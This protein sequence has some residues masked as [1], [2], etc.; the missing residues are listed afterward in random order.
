MARCRI[1]REWLSMLSTAS[2]A[3]LVV[4]P[5]L[6][7]YLQDASSAS[8]KLSVALFKDLGVKGGSGYTV[9]QPDLAFC[10]TCVTA[11]KTGKMKIAGNVKDSAFI[12]N[13]FCN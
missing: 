12:Y 7:K 3:S 5:K 11:I 9:S 1:A 4:F 10:L 8:P 6:V 13:G 2:R